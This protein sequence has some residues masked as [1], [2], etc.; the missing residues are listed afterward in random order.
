ML[1]F[2]NAPVVLSTRAHY[3]DQISRP[4]PVRGDGGAI[5]PY[6]QVQL[7]EQQLTSAQSAIVI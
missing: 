2:P 7:D 5:A 4:A 1:L 6:K 3:V